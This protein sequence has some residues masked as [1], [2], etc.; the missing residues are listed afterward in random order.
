MNNRVKEL[1]TELGLSIRKFADDINLTAGTISLIENG[2]RNL[3]DRSISDICRI[4]HVNELWLRTGEGS[5]FQ[6]RTREIEIAEMTAAMYKAD[7]NDFQYQLMKL[8]AQLTPEQ[9]HMLR[10]IVEQLH[11]GISSEE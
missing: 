8:I 7:E 5:M 9:V 2:K 4:Y 11:D 1:R 10:E 6:E 3:T